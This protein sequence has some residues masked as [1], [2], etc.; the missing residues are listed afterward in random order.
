MDEFRSIIMNEKKKEILFIV[1]VIM[2]ALSL[3]GTI[4]FFIENSIIQS[5]VPYEQEVTIQDKFFG[6]SVGWGI[7]STTGESYFYYPPNIGFNLIPGH[8]YKFNLTNDY[9]IQNG[10][11]GYYAPRINEFEE[12]LL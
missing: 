11:W 10:I 5:H 8:T 3:A 7:I 6:D 12:V 1:G 9:Y 4:A 2:V